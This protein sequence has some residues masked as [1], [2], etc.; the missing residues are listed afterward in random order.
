[1]PS[2]DTIEFQDWAQRPGNDVGI[3]ERARISTLHFHVSQDLNPTCSQSG[4]SKGDAIV[5]RVTPGFDY[6]TIRI[7]VDGSPAASHR[8]SASKMFMTVL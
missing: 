6:T 1:V 7:G 2:T 4:F 5:G 8:T 3:G